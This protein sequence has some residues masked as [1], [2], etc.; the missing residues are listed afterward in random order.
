MVHTRLCKNHKNTIFLQNEAISGLW[1][2]LGRPKYDFEEFGRCFRNCDIFS[3][4]SASHGHFLRAMLNTRGPIVIRGMGGPP[5]AWFFSKIKQ[6]LGFNYGFEGPKMWF[7]GIWKIFKKVDIL[8]ETKNVL[9]TFYGQFWRSEA[10]NGPYWIWEDTKSI[11][12][13]K[14]NQILAIEWVCGS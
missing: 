4:I 1:M 9:D 11:I 10:K 14:M 6:F 3:K 2:G 13:C 5:K 8:S 7:W 12:I